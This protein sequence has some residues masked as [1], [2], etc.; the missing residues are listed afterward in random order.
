MDVIAL[1]AA[2]FKN[3][4]ATLGTALTQEQAR[5]IKKYTNKVVLSYDSDGAGKAATDRASKILGEVGIDVRV[6]RVTGAKDP[7]EYIK[8]FGSEAFKMLLKGSDTKFDYVLKTVL[9]KYD[10]Q[11]TDGKIKASKELCK[12]IASVESTVE[13]EIYIDKTAKVLGVSKESIEGDVKKALRTKNRERTVAINKQLQNKALGI[14]DRV[15]PEYSANPKAAAA[16]EAILGIMM[17]FPEKKVKIASGQIEINENDFV[18]SLN[19]RIFAE[20]MRLHQDGVNDVG[21]LG[22]VFTQTEMERVY[23]IQMKRSGLDSASDTVLLDNIY[24]LKN[25]KAS[26]QTDDI[27]MIIKAKLSGKQ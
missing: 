17:L 26:A 21:A 24:A 6:L 7:D 4:V 1:H 15:N 11:T 23:A 13:R 8:T 25:A 18:T 14:G 2:G 20:L 19:K 5:L 12:E 9:S 27:D 22:A 16:E 3:A 10:A